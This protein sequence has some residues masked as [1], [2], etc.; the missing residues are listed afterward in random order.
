MLQDEAERALVMGAALHC[1][2]E[3]VELLVPDMSL[4]HLSPE[5]P[6]RFGERPHARVN[7]QRWL[8]MIVVDEQAQVAG[9]QTATQAKP[10]LTSAFVMVQNQGKSETGTGDE[11]RYAWVLERPLRPEA[12]QAQIAQAARI[13]RVLLA[14]YREV[15]EELYRSR[16]I[17]ESVTNGI[18]LS[19]ATVQD[20]PLVYINP[21]FEQMTGYRRDEVYGRNCRFLQGDERDQPA[22]AQLRTAIRSSQPAQVLLRNFRKDG[23]LFWNELYLSPIRGID[24]QVTH[25]V[26]IQNDVTER[27]EATE[28]LSYLALHDALTGLANRT[29]LM[30]QLQQALERARRGGSIVAVLFFD[31]NNFKELNDALGHEAGDQ[32][33]K[34]VASRLR[35]SARSCETVA[36]LES[37]AR[38]G[39]DEFV[40]VLEGLPDVALHQVVMER[41]LRKLVEP[42]EI[43]GSTVLPATSVGVA[44]YPRDGESA[45][46]LL[47]AA[48]AA[49]YR[50]KRTGET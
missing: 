45:E 36:R 38:L 13:N 40:V 16:T 32:L 12:V 10:V 49:M 2:L 9:W 34:T 26:G 29:L 44:F 11:P 1:G 42:T 4:V 5:S 21:A 28:R 33:L 39:G 27:V 3:P 19:D 18:V 8:P 47:R 14:Q 50:D 20:M 23:E 41:F 22:V 46:E 17:F 43:M 48:D 24:E 25:Y 37:V 6:S 15:L 30:E 31:L 35:E 7:K